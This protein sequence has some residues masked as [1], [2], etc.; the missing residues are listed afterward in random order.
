[1]FETSLRS[2]V[3]LVVALALCHAGSSNVVFSAGDG[4]NCVHATTP[5]YCDGV[6]GR[7]CTFGGNKCTS[8]DDY[9]S[10]VDGTGGT[11]TVCDHVFGCSH[12]GQ[13]Y[14]TTN[15]TGCQ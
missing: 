4:E 8:G 3:L 13:S 9:S 14:A 1:M 7:T 2:I 10:C 15:A 11:V 12:S 6:Q 5:D